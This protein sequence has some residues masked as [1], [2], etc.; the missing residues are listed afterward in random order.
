MIP[1]PD[2]YADMHPGELVWL[3]RMGAPFFAHEGSVTMVS[4]EDGWSVKVC[5]APEFAVGNLGNAFTGKRVVANWESI[6]GD[7]PADRCLVP[8]VPFCL[9]GT[10]TPENLMRLTHAEAAAI[11]RDMRAL[12]CGLKRG[13]RVL[14]GYTGHGGF[15]RQFRYR[16][17][18][19]PA[20]RARFRPCA[21]HPRTPPGAVRRR[22]LQ[23]A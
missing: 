1:D 11:Y 8:M 4:P 16:Y 10:T 23:P 20:R 9:G 14:F 13:D 12:F 6:H 21:P 22:I 18:E 19:A 2:L 3:N 15:S 5:G 7:L 17:T